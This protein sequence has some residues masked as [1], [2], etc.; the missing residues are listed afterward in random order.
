MTPI[1]QTAFRSLGL[2]IAIF[3]FYEEAFACPVCY[4]DPESNIVSSIFAGMFYL[5][6]VAGVVFGGI[7][8]F[9]YRMNERQKLISI[10]SNLKSR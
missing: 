1:R 3:V 10:K 6:G 9:F 5:L 2:V 4:G 8:V 7:G